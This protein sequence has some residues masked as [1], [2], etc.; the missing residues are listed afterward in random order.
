[1]IGRIVAAKIKAIHEITNNVESRGKMKC[2]TTKPE[3]N[4]LDEATFP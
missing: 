2:L 3:V 1:M 4:A